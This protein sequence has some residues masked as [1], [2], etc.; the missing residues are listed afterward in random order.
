M[1]IDNKNKYAQKRMIKELEKSFNSWIILN[2]H[3]INKIQQ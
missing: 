1:I 3:D 2:V